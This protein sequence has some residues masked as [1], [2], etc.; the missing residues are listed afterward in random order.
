M[1]HLPRCGAASG[2]LVG[3]PGSEYRLFAT[4]V[5]PIFESIY[6]D[7]KK[8]PRAPVERTNEHCVW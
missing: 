7:A 1:A 3:G 8:V 2:V 4:A 5:V 6:S